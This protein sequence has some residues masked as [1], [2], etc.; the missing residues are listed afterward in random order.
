VNDTSPTALPSRRQLRE[1]E[2]K[3]TS[4]VPT[5]SVSRRER[6]LLEQASSN[7]LDSS[8]SSVMSDAPSPSPYGATGV[9]ASVLVPPPALD[10]PAPVAHIAPIAAAPQ[11]VAPTPPAPPAPPPAPLSRRQLREQQ[12]ALAPQA[13]PTLPT[14][15]QPV[16]LGQ[17]AP[18]ASPLVTAPA[19]TALPPVFSTPAQAASVEAPT[20]PSRSVGVSAPATNA[21]ILPTAPSLDLAG[22]LG[23]TGEILVT[24]NIPLPRLVSENAMTGLVDV[25]TE[26]DMVS[27]DTGAFTAPVRATQAVSTRSMEIDQ[28]MIKKP[29]WG[30]TSMVLAFS[31]AILGV[32]ALGLLALALLTDIITLPF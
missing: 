6:R 31:A 7:P 10:S 2:S 27:V 1:Q 24:G 21:L 22:P 32:T 25:D 12:A 26:D 15:L 8:S 14:P 17:V 4:S 16:T 13:E 3:D 18:A 11:M 23:D 28:P 30:M 5:R 19:P 20:A 9:S 29:S